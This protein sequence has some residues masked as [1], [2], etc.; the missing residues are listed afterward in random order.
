MHMQ[1][2]LMQLR[3]QREALRRGMAKVPQ[4]GGTEAMLWDPVLVGT[5]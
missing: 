2:R 4:K 3:T 5:H 1:V